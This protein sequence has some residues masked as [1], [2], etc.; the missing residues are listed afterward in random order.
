M[1]HVGRVKD[2]AVV[3]AGKHNVSLGG[4]H[5]VLDEAGDPFGKGEHLVL[6]VLFIHGFHYFV[7]VAVEAGMIAVSQLFSEFLGGTLIVKP[8]RTAIGV[9][10]P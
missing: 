8:R 10:A 7:K 1:K 4:K 9:N 2:Q 6:A 5:E 3:F